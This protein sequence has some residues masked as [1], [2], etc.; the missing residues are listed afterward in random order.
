MSLVRLIQSQIVFK[1]LFKQQQNYLQL[2]QKS[3]L[4]TSNELTNKDE[5]EDDFA[6]PD[7]TPEKE[8]KLEKEKLFVEL[9]TKKQCVSRF[10]TKNAENKF[11]CKLPM[12][13]PNSLALGNKKFFRKIYARHG[14][15]SNVDPRVCWPSRDELQEIIDDE[16][17]YDFSLKHKIDTIAK[18]KYDEA[19]N[20]SEK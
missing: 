20:V 6:D 17:N 3:S 12:L 2:I 10:S 8:E 14:S 16:K 11:H 7:M 18:M 9:I 19:N 4:A 1:N 5:D 15:E 13:P